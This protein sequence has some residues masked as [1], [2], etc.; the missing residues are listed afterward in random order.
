MISS[1]RNMSNSKVGM[2]III[3]IGALIVFSFA[4]ADI[5]NVG[6]GGSGNANALAEAGD[7]PVTD[8]EMSD[9]LEQE[10][11]RLRQQNPE[12]QYSDLDASFDAILESLLTDR[13]LKAFAEEN[14]FILSKRLI[15]AE[16]ARLPG[17]TGADGKFSDEAYRGF[18]SQQR[19]TDAQIR[20]AF[21]SSLYQ[22]LMLVPV[23]AELRVPSGIAR[24]YAS[25]LLEQRDAD[26]VMV[27]ARPL[28]ESIE[29]TDADLERFYRASAAR[30]TV[31]ERRV[32]K[33]APITA[34]TVAAASPTAA[35]IDQMLEARA[36]EFAPRE[37]RVI[38]QVV[39]P[40]EATA[41]RVATTARSGSFVD[42]VAPEG[43][44]AAD[45]SVGPQTREQ[46][47]TLTSDAVAAATFAN[48]VGGGAIVGPVRSSFGWHVVR[49]ESVATEGGVSP[50]A[51]RETVTAE[52]AA[53]KRQGALIDMVTRIENLIAD[54]ASFD[55]AV[56]EVGIEPITTP[57][58]TAS[59]R[60]LDDPE[61]QFP[62][63]YAGTLRNGFQLF[64]DDDPEIAN[65]GEDTGFA[66][67]A[68][69]AIIE[70][71][72]APLA[73]I[74][75]QVR[76]DYV[77]REALNR[78]RAIASDIQKAIEGG[79]APEAAAA[80]A[81]ADSGIEIPAIRRITF[82]RLDLAQFQGDVPAP[83]Q[84]MF[85]LAE[86]QSQLTSDA[87][88]QGI[89]VVKV[90]DIERGDAASNP[91]LVSQTSRD[92]RQLI[93]NELGEQFLRAV[94]DEVGISRN[95]RAIA[96]TRTRITGGGQ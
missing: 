58:I 49:V 93:G 18:L 30:Y 26:V 36:D 14:D 83:V 23:A 61:Y 11:G 44:S 79:A 41:R 62:A 22:R 78:A 48:G 15:D 86:G 28:R 91:G 45:V 8:R 80:A 68:A 64:A 95:E 51:A 81:A 43:F 67:V 4:M 52:L 65:L 33:I 89:Y 21:A 34:D 72:P 40:D 29:V 87:Q 60:N 74:R 54:G 96:A 53:A 71:A 85:N 56:R 12:A 92:F 63:R 27:P 37:T 88:G 38:S 16:I 84:M 13:A 19:I 76:A 50:A 59:G 77:E 7:E 31:P 5:S 66:L 42:A 32:L 73:E 1:F 69:D 94:R 6:V 46:F 2:A 10:L 25:M 35:E 3:V 24:P 82:R 55:E 17:V 90:T 39:L 9:A 57:A 70:P 75:E 20:Q 47:A